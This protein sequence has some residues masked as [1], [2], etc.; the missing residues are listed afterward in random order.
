MD[1]C[2]QFCFVLEMQ[3]VPIPYSVVFASGDDGVKDAE[4]LPDCAR[5]V[6]EYF[7]GQH[8]ASQE[9]G[10][11]L[12]LSI[13]MVFATVILCV[14]QRQESVELPACKCRCV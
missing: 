13:A 6:D 8:I 4:A 2:W 7:A 12:C 5:V 9:H 3:P 1:A 14:R 10:K 11:S